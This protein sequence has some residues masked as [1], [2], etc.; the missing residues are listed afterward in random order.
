VRLKNRV[1]I[2]T[3]AGQGI[4]KAIAEALAKEGAAAVVA[5]V[6]FKNAS[7]VA[8][9]IQKGGGRGLAVKCNVAS[10]EEVE[11]MVKKTVDQFG[12]VDIL[13][14]NAGIIRP[15][16][17]LKMTDE[18]W[19]Q[20]LNVHLKGSFLCLQVAA[21]EM[22]KKNYGRIINITSA[23]GILGTIGQINYS[24]AKSGILGLTKSAAKELAR[25]NILVNCIAPG[26][27]TKMTEVIR[28]DEKF[29][30]KYLE[31]IPLARWAEPEEI[32][33]CVVFLASEGSSYMTGQVFAVDGGMTIF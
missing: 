11:A 22:I 4:G 21:R 10:R 24:S 30:D 7:L 8:E 17:L 27:A 14:N 29:K 20:V 18:Q 26:A 3:G 15:A 6:D 1:G 5:D 13:V 28:T 32:A 19:D 23:A 16:M 9:G 12:Q 31:R 25:C 33:P 2:I